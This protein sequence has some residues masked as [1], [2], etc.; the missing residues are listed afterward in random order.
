MATCSSDGRLAKM[1]RVSVVRYF[2]AIDNAA[3]HSDPPPRV[4]MRDVNFA[5]NPQAIRYLEDFQIAYTIGVTSPV[6][7]DNPPDPSVDLA[8]VPLTADNMLSGVRI[9]VTARSVTAGLEGASEG[10]AGRSDD[11]IWKTFSTNVNPR[12][13]AQAVREGE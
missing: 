13:L 3:H 9:T 11:F 4:L 1:T 6:D 8:G 12:R 7:Q 2:T 5:G 10:G